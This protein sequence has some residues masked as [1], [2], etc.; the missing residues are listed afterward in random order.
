MMNCLTTPSRLPQWTHLFVLSPLVVALVGC[1]SGPDYTRPESLYVTEFATVE[2]PTKTVESPGVHGGS[3]QFA[4]ST[5][6]GEWWKEFKSDK[7]NNLIVQAL[8][9]SPSLAAAQATLRQ[10]QHNR[11]ASSGATELPQINAK[12]GAQRLGANNAAAGLPQGERTYDLYSAT[13]AVSYDLDLAGG[14]RRALEALT[15]QADY[16]SYQLEGSRL[17]LAANLVLTAITQAQLAAQIDATNT[18]LRGQAEQIAITRKR[19]ELGA[20]TQL[21]IL[22]LEAQMEQTRA[23]LHG[24]QNKKEQTRHLL[25]VLSGNAPVGKSSHDF[26]LADFSLPGTLPISVPS[27]W[28]R[29]RPDVRASEALLQTASA[30]YGVAISKLYPQLTLTANLGSQALTTASLF[31]AGSLIW[32]L[33]GQLLQ[34]LF[35]PGLRANTKALEAGMDAA[36]AN[37][38]QTVL[39]SLRNV[40]DVLRTVENDALAQQSLE[41]AHSSATRALKMVERQY[42]LGSVS[43]LQLLLSQQQVQQA[44]INT[45]EVRARRLSNTVTLYQAMGGGA[46][47]PS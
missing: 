11:A 28:V 7:L 35:N 19:A 22:A 27:E 29:R 6:P 31:G 4:N 1:A 9:A 12:L 17:T 5:T 43:Y 47:V 2:H 44:H 38:Q 14:N 10:A 25:A 15:A 23:G 36:K 24:F 26:E 20:G 18:L 46:L 32:G 41:S 21:E 45:L 34:P 33:G 39:Q 3:Q 8:D 37:Y 30:Q 13:V 16:Q 42:A 40:A